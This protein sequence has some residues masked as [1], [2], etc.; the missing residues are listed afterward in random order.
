MPKFTYYSKLFVTNW[1]CLQSMLQL[2]HLGSSHR[3]KN[4]SGPLENGTIFI[5]IITKRYCFAPLLQKV[6]STC[7]TQSESQFFI[8]VVQIPTQITE[9]KLTCS[10]SLGS[11]EPAVRVPPPLPITP[12]VAA[13]CLLLPGPGYGGGGLSGN[14]S[15]LVDAVLIMLSGDWLVVRET[16]ESDLVSNEPAKVTNR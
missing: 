7:S 12:L 15:E 10:G 4:S 1:L 2:A 6:Y 5:L 14:R 3:H 16:G 13:C 11:D 9:Q 8:Q